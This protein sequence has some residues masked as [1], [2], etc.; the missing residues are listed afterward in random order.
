MVLKND[1]EATVL[2]K[3]RV[4]RERAHVRLRAGERTDVTKRRKV[5]ERVFRYHRLPSR[6]Y[7]FIKHLMQRG[8]IYTYNG[9]YEFTVK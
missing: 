1:S 7:S 5:D 3:S 8:R 2:R 9:I 6:S 4:A